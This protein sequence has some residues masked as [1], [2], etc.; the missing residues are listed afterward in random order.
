MLEVYYTVPWESVDALIGE[1]SMFWRV[2]RSLRCRK[3]SCSGADA[4]FIPIDASFLLHILMRTHTYYVLP[5]V[6]EFQMVSI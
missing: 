4:E 1:S 6:Q 3:Q 2:K 5:T